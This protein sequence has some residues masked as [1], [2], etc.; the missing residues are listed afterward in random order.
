MSELKMEERFA[1]SHMTV[2]CVAEGPSTAVQITEENIDL[3]A[4]WCS[5][6][7][8][9]ET[10]LDAPGP[11]R[12][13]AVNTRD[14]KL[15][16]MVERAD[17]G[18]WLVRSAD[19]M[20]YFRVYSDAAFRNLYD[21]TP[22]AT[23]TPNDF[24]RAA[25]ITVKYEDVVQDEAHVDIVRDKHEEI[26]IRTTELVLN[27]MEYQDSITQRGGVL[28]EGY[29]VAGFVGLSVRRMIET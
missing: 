26:Q 21:L 27:A 7:L 1:L 14:R 16:P 4:K 3:L 15:R 29:P 18:D 9:T 19:G 17:I 2:T 11:Y 23:E 10:P 28:D 5:G 13:I 20:G 8:T 24:R 12:Y 25:G 22:V 6:E